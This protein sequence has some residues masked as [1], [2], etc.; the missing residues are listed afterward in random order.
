MPC[1]F[2]LLQQL[3]EHSLINV[4]CLS[5]FSIPRIIPCRGGVG[6]RLLCNA[7]LNN[8]LRLGIRE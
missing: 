1:V 2:M 3:G 6:L 5:R 7:A 4:K 8:R